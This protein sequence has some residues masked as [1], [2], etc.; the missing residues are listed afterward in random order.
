VKQ[1]QTK[2]PRSTGAHADE[3]LFPVFFNLQGRQCVVAGGGTVAQRKTAQLLECGARVVIVSPSATQQIKAWSSQGR[4]TWRRGA[5]TTGHL[6][7]AFMVF[8]ATASSRTNKS[9]AAACRKQGILVTVADS[10]AL[11][12][13]FMPAVLRRKALAVAISTRGSSPLL[14][15]KIRAELEQILTD[16]HG[17]FID[18]LGDL[19]RRLRRSVPDA[20]RRRKIFETI[21]D[22]DILALLKEGK[23]AEA[24]KRVRQ[25]I[26]SS[27]D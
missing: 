9:I 8:A 24:E 19:R 16:A 21:A 2:P 14:A 5:W 20:R 18:M 17:E 1:Q 12:D 3:H 13:F 11:C 4:L 23:R 27:P 10:P 22:S 6:A 25:C 15:R 26:L 7:G